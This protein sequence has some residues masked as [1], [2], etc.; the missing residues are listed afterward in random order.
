MSGILLAEGFMYDK[1]KGMVTNRPAAGRLP[2]A[3]GTASACVQSAQLL[4]LRHPIGHPARTARRC[5]LARP[6]QGR[7]SG[8]Q[9][10]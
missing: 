3:A 9:T 6:A 7:S 4:A 10:G 2:G 8:H 1:L 5:G